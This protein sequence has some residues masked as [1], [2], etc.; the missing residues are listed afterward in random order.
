MGRPAKISWEKIYKEFRRNYSALA[1]DT[2]HWEPRDFLEITLFMKD[3]SKIKY[4]Y[5]TKKSS[6]TNERWK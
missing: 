1:K 2:L 3:G 4:N 5:L 6:L